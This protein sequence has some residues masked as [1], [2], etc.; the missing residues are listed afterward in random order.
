M[1]VPDKPFKLEMPEKATGGMS[2]LMCGSTRSGKTTFMKHLLDKDFKQHITILMS[3][4]IHAPAYQDV[5]NDALCCDDFDGEIIKDMFVI[6]KKTD[7]HYDFCVVLDDIVTKKFDK[8]ILKLFTTHRNANISGI[9]CI[10]S[11][12]LLNSAMRGNVNVV[13]LGFMNSDESCEKVIRMFCYASIPG[14][15]IEEKINAYK[16]LTRDHHWIVCDNLTGDL[17]RTKLSL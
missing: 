4:N 15:N 12:V 17:Y 13:M 5:S 14:K 6:N 11:P 10:Q 2:I 7:N 9:M 8:D 3:P 1:P 16:G